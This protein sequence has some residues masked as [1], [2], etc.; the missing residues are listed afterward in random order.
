MQARA[1]DLDLQTVPLPTRETRNNR[2]SRIDIGLEESIL[3]TARANVSPRPHTEDKIPGPIHSG[4]SSGE[5]PAELTEL[6][7]LMQF[8]TSFRE[9]IANENFLDLVPMISLQYDRVVLRSSAASAV[10]L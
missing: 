4:E 6:F 9:S 7:P 8:Y 10:C 5:R 1:R 2:T 3:L